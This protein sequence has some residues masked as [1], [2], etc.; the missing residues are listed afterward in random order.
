VREAYHET[1][2]AE[3]LE[4]KE[5]GNQQRHSKGR[6]SEEVT[7]FS[8]ILRIRDSSRSRR[9]DHQSHLHH[10]C[11]P[12]IKSKEVQKNLVAKCAHLIYGNESQ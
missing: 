6:R 8:S 2:F 5:Y 10:H 7:P 9:F 12:T 11:N 4:K 1:K 3:Q